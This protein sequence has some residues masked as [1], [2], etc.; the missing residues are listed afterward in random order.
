M[1]Q[2]L[3]AELLEDFSS[4]IADFE[5]VVRRARDN[6]PTDDRR[7]GALLDQLEQAHEELRVADEELRVQQ[8]ELRH[9]VEDVRAHTWQHERLLAALPCPVLTTDLNGIIGSVNGPAAAALNIATHR[10]VRR[11]VQSFAPAGERPVLRRQLAQLAR[12]GGQLRM[13]VTLT[14]RGGEP[15]LMDAVVVAD[16]QPKTGEPKFTWLLVP[17]GEDTPWQPTREGSHEEHP[18]AGHTSFAGSILDLTRL[19]VHQSDR[20]EILASAARICRHALG[21]TVSISV[22][23]GPPAEPERLATTDQ[24]AQ[25]IDGAQIRAG[26]GPCQTAYQSRVAVWSPSLHRDE[27][28]PALGNGI[29][30]VAV[31]WTVAAPVHVGDTVMGALNVYGRTAD[32]PPGFRAGVE[33]LSGAL[34]GVLHELELKAELEAT[35][36]NLRAGLTSRATIDQAKGILMATHNDTPDEAFERLVGMSN[37]QNVKLR[38]IA[39]QIV[40]DTGS[41]GS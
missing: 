14:P 13:P 36:R 7:T 17:R 12:N 35:A 23:V 9:F 19:P 8:E 4:V 25:L 28:W 26:E 27:R 20:T 21:D 18:S 29:R 33:L 34:G 2:E 41:Q 3:S 37:S 39:A 6:S 10:L 22:T 30:D 24:L 40:A 31:T 11:P 32:C 5:Q 38:D 1:S 15:L 16:R